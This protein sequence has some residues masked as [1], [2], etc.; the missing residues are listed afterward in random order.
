MAHSHRILSLLQPSGLI[1][2]PGLQRLH[3]GDDFTTNGLPHLSIQPGTA[4][5]ELLQLLTIDP[6]S[7]GHRFNRLALSR[8]QEALHVERRALTTL[9][10]PK[11][12]DKGFDESLQLANLSLPVRGVP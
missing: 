1:H 3:H 6:K 7:L 5:D 2:D 12:G 4:T 9:A 11:V 8:H 10:A